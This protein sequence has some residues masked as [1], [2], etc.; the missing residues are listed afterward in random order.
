[1]GGN[2]E[3][4]TEKQKRYLYWLKRQDKIN[5]SNEKIESL[6]RE[7]ASSLIDQAKQSR[8]PEDKRAMKFIEIYDQSKDIVFDMLDQL[9][10]KDAVDSSVILQEIGLIARTLYINKGK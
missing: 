1:M 2:P 3:P 4:A 9:P 5:L 6:S 10:N 8:K 7:E